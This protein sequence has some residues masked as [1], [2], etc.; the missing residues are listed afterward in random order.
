MYIRGDGP[1]FTTIPTSMMIILIWSNEKKSVKERTLDSGSCW[2]SFLL[3]Q[4][5][6]GLHKLSIR[7]LYTCAKLRACLRKTALCQ[8]EL[9]PFPE[10]SEPWGIAGCRCGSSG[11]GRCKWPELKRGH[12]CSEDIR[13]CPLAESVHPRA[14]CW[15]SPVTPSSGNYLSSLGCAVHLTLNQI[16]QL[17]WASYSLCFS[18]L[19]FCKWRCA[20]LSAM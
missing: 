13:T 8:R 4:L 12:T 6:S 5:V 10:R 9:L 11:K 20:W 2:E 18:A 3:Q 15:H 14:K 17:D 19:V 7:E 16:S 1:P